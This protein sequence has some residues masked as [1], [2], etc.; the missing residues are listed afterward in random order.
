MKAVILAAGV[1]KRLA[2]AHAGPKCLLRFGG[3]TLLERHLERLRAAGIRDVVL[4]LGYQ[5]QQVHAELARIGAAGWVTTIVNPD[6]EQGSVVSLWTVRE[7]LDPVA[8]AIVMDADV[9]YGRGLLER[10]AGSRHE[11]CFLLDREFEPGEEPVKLCV[12]GQVLVEFRKRLA[13]DLSYD[14][15]GESIGF[16]RFGGAMAARLAASVDAYRDTGR[17]E[18]PHEEA[19]RDLLLESPGE[20]GFEDVTGMPWTEIDFERDVVRAQNQI[21]PLID[22]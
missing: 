14:Y 10:L 22:E 1:G 17:G 9:L 21:L 12:R 20:F 2:A 6:Y 16:F 5:A 18:E 19:I 15:C 11:N 7:H 3:R 13:P 4:C 8:G